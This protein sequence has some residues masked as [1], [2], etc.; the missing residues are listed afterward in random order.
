VEEILA[1]MWAPVGKVAATALAIG[2]LVHFVKMKL[3]SPELRASPWG[4]RAT[5]VLPV[6]LGIACFFVPGVLPGESDGARLES[7]LLAGLLAPW[8]YNAFKRRQAAAAGAAPPQ[9]KDTP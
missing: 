6:L 1:S 4:K 7:A 8:A 5:T 9:D 3:L 2:L